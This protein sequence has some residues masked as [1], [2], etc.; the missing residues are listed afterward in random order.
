[1]IQSPIIES[2]VI[3]INKIFIPRFNHKKYLMY[4]KL[5]DIIFF[6]LRFMNKSRINWN[7]IYLLFS[8]FESFIVYSRL[9][10]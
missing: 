8:L 2:F 7:C 10:L 3:K 1:M 5:N 9:F 4:N 6:C